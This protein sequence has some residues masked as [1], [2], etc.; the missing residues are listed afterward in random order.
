MGYEP[1][2]TITCPPLAR[3]AR[4]CPHGYALMGFTPQAKYICF[5][6]L[7][8]LFLS[9][10]RPAHQKKSSFGLP[11][12]GALQNLPFLL[13]RFIYSST[14]VPAE[15]PK[16]TTTAAPKR[17][18]Y[19]SIRDT[20]PPAWVGAPAGGGCTHM[21]PKHRPGGGLDSENM[22]FGPPLWSRT[23][24]KMAPPEVSKGCMRHKH[25]RKRKAVRH[26]DAD[27]C[28]EVCHRARGVPNS[29]KKLPAR[30]I[31]GSTRAPTEMELELQLTAVGC[32]QWRLGC[33]RPR[34]EGGP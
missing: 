5:V 34:L 21:W 17:H 22:V 13:A 18:P 32:N 33:N 27:T 8:G 6:A 3:L 23:Y 20:V 2:P 29:R 10:K 31:W 28:G 9:S 4:N 12:S 30:V 11:A 15:R 7:R 16:G 1:L 19:T 26:R 25:K 24:G 14:V